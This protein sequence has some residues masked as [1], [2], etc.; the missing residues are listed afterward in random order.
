MASRTQLLQENLCLQ[1]YQV[2]ILH[3]FLKDYSVIESP[4]GRSS[5]ELCLL[6]EGAE[7]MI[8]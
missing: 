6:A 1:E 8:F 7:D 5:S 2:T 4:T 3:V